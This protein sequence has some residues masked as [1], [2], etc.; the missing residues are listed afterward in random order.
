[1]LKLLVDDT[2]SIRLLTLYGHVKIAPPT[3]KPASK[4]SNST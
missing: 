3:S 1:M 4:T 2:K